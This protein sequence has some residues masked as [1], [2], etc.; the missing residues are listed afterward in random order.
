[1]A[2]EDEASVD[3]TLDPPTNLGAPTVTKESELGGITVVTLEE[4]EF[5]ERFPQPD[6][7]DDSEIDNDDFHHDDPFD[8]IELEEQEM[9]DAVNKND[10]IAGWIAATKSKLLLEDTVKQKFDLKKERGLFHLFLNESLFRALW[11]WTKCRLEE[12]G[13]D[14]SSVPYEK[15]MAYVGLEV[16]MSLVS[17]SEIRDYWK[18][19]RFQGQSDFRDTMSY[20]DFQ[21]IRGALQFHPPDEYERVDHDN[22]PLWAIRRVMEHFQKNCADVAVPVGT[23]ALDENSARSKH[24]TLA[25]SYMKGKPHKYA[26]RFYG[27]VGGRD[28]YLPSI[29]D[30]GSGNTEP[31]C[32]AERYTKLFRQMRRPF[33]K[34]FDK[35]PTGKLTQ[36]AIL[37]CR[38][39]PRMPS[40][41]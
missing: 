1:M 23:S 19:G 14:A 6:L 5:D 7:V 9:R 29:W 33:N 40:L 36:C 26:M 28:L 30:N 39:C 38:P 22:D 25:R 27:V 32:P 17:M 15:F 24:R 16:A 10:Y 20:K 12:R 2:S 31:T 13:S 37:T 18:T 3:S 34:L 11:H 35:D 21:A 41:R 8:V 4:K